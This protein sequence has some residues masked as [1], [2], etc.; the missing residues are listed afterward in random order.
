[1][2]W[3]RQRRWE[4][5]AVDDELPAL[6][7]PLSVRRLVVAAGATRDFNPAHHDSEV[8]RAGG[9][10]DMYANTIFLLG[11]WERALREFI[12]LQGTIRRLGGGRMRAFNVPGDVLVVRGR[13]TRKWRDGALALLEI[14]VWT[15]NGERISVGPGTATVTL[16]AGDA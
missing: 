5:V 9:A 7:F 3:D 6:S 11:M 13:V 4:D 2:K 10:P 16:P 14:D 1:V 12:G 15:D 8:A